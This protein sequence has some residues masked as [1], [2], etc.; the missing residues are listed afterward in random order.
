MCETQMESHV[1]STWPSVNWESFGEW[2]SRCK[3]FLSS[4]LTL[5]HYL[6]NKY[7]FFFLKVNCVVN[8]IH[9]SI[10]QKLLP[11]HMASQSHLVE[12]PKGHRCHHVNMFMSQRN[13]N[14][15]IDHIWTTASTYLFCYLF[16]STQL[17]SVNPNRPGTLN[18]WH[19][20]NTLQPI[21]SLAIHTHSC[22]YSH[23]SF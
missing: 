13:K 8:D 4:F 19:L 21:R 12:I 9:P 6:S 18:P 17:Q 11:A 23:V 5:F 10:W 7:M 15:S 20:P 2:S 1:I 14:A 3:I 16:W 22:Y